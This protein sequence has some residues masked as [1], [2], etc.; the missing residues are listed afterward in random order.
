MCGIATGHYKVDHLERSNREVWGRE[1]GQNGS[2]V[3]PAE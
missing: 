2:G 1:G 3:G